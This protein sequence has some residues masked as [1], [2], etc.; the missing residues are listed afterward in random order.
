MGNSLNEYTDRLRKQTVSLQRF[1]QFNS[2]CGNSEQLPKYYGVV[3]R[4]CRLLFP[5]IH[6]R[7]SSGEHLQGGRTREVFWLC[8]SVTGSPGVAQS[9]NMFSL[10]PKKDK[11]HLNAAVC[12][13]PIA[14]V[15][16]DASTPCYFVTGYKKLT[17]C[18]L[19]L[20][21]LTVG[22]FTITT[23]GH[24]KESGHTCQPRDSTDPRL[25]SPHS[26]SKNSFKKD[27]FWYPCSVYPIRT[28]NS[29]KR[30]SSCLLLNLVIT[31]PHS[32]GNC[33]R[34]LGPSSFKFTATEY[35]H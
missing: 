20:W 19:L 10:R 27:I 4:K 16:R 8:D 25:S 7:L 21:L 32:C 3:R 31:V 34:N 29:L 23:T 26:C 2:D 35:L 13:T 9:N 33:D 18:C 14:T 30:H 5:Q 17:H 12:V 28:E 22:T 6:S 1:A 24:T 15:Q 11:N